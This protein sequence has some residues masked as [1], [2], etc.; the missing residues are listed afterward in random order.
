VLLG[1]MLPDP[2]PLVVAQP[3]HGGAL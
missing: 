2:L 1:K 3:Q